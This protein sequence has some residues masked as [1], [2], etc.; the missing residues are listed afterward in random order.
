L[1]QYGAAGDSCIAYFAWNISKYRSHAS[2]VNQ[3]PRVI[4]EES[5]AV[6]RAPM[7]TVN[8]AGSFK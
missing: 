8:C 4:G 7:S 1:R 5:G 6:V 3:V 2:G